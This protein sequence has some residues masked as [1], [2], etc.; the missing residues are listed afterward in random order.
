MLMQP[1]R[2][3][4]LRTLWM[5]AIAGV[6][7]FALWL[8]LPAGGGPSLPGA[9]DAELPP[10]LRVDGAVGSTSVD[11]AVTELRV[12]LALRGADPIRLTEDGRI[13]AVTAMAETASAAVPASYE[14]TWP[15]GDGDDYL[16]PGERALL[17]VALPAGSPVTD[18]NPAKLVIHPIDGPAL[19]IENVLP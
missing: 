9:G 10:S 3:L 8:L 4:P 18:T 17:T 2:T 1:A 12:P 14:V 16:E 11:G 7:A 19:T 5:A 13:H 6:T 15:A